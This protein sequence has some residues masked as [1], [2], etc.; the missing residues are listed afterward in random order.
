M[1]LFTRVNCRWVDGPCC[2]PVT[3][4][5]SPM[6]TQWHHS[7]QQS[8][9][10]LP[11]PTYR[12]CGFTTL[13]VHLGHYARHAAIASN[14]TAP[15][16][17]EANRH[18]IPPLAQLTCWL[19]VQQT[20]MSGRL[21]PILHISMKTANFKENCQGIIQNRNSKAQRGDA[22]TAYQT[23]LSASTSACCRRF[24]SS[25]CRFSRLLLSKSSSSV[26]RAWHSIRFV[27]T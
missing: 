9:A 7:P 2:H 13:L 10:G 24:V 11:K 20:D 26:T 8:N 5:G 17:R 14:C 4:A 16:L 1:V 23:D 6:L 22:E 3:S 27:V 25:C 15:L 21:N 18:E 19:Y 12:A